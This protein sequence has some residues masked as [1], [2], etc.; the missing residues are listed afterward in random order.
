MVFEKN[1]KNFEKGFEE[2]LKDILDA[3]INERIKRIKRTPSVRILTL[4]AHRHQ[5]TFK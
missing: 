4:G 1:F 3:N 2:T 5:C